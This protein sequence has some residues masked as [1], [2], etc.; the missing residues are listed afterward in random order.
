MERLDVVVIGG[1]LVGAATAFRLVQAGASVAVVEA[2]YPNIGASG[3]NA[4]SLHFQLERRFLE[5]GESLAD[6]AAG[7]L[8]LN[9][10]AIDE[11]KALDA[12]LGPDV[13]IHMK[14]GLMVAETADEVRTLER[15]V[16][17]EAA[18]GL[19]SRLVDGDEARRIAPG[20]SKT[21]V[22]AA[23]LAAE[24]HADP[25][26]L[27]PTF[28]MRAEHGGARLLQNT[29]VTAVRSEAGGYRLTICQGTVEK[30]LAAR[31]VLIAAGAWTGRV[32]ELFNLH[33]PIYPVALLMNVTER[34][35]PVLE[36]LI[37]HVGQRLSMKQA[38]AGNILIG[39]GWP[40][41]MKLDSTGRFDPGQSA[42][43]LPS[44][45][46]G[47][48]AVAS[49]V[50]PRI[51]DL[52][53]IRSWTGVTAITADQTPLVGEVPQAPGV[54]VAAGGSAFTLGPVFARLLA[55]LILEEKEERLSVFSPARFS[56]LN[57]FMGGRLA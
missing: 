53:L 44:S 56:H 41:R 15:K 47:N 42:E 37:Q 40:S 7:I 52:N 10:L 13:H 16:A 3:A 49:R 57:S 18:G 24:G 43:M 34:T 8:S 55:R 22:A 19:G 20:L 6:Q 28:I 30:E 17:R 48:L 29:R 54:Y 27:T 39:G 31:K 21:V 9:R 38:H 35:P 51:A 12:E 1:G 36:Q 11:W 2:G 46:S 4:G 14:G 45:L 33:L 5:N 26:A 32:G 50:F 25:K 23:Y